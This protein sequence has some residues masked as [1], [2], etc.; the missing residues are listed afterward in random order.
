MHG[1]MFRKKTKKR[2][3]GGG[4]GVAALIKEKYRKQRIEERKEAS[5]R[6]REE[7]RQANT[8]H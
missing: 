3:S 8:N 2:C 5:A 7:K 4:Y 6:A 1:E